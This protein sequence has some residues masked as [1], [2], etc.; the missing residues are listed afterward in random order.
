MSH[1][2][3]ASA[4]T[5]G[6]GYTTITAP[7]T[8]GAFAATIGAA[9]PVN[10]S[11][12]TVNNE[13]SIFSLGGWVRVVEF[14]SGTDSNVLF[15]ASGQFSLEVNAS[16]L[17]LARFSSNTASRSVQS[18]SGI[19]DNEWHY[20]VVAFQQAND[21]T[22][23]GQVK[24]VVDG[25]PV[26]D[27]GIVTSASSSSV[28]QCVI[29]SGQLEFVSWTIWSV[30]LSTKE[31]QV[32]DFGPPVTGS[33]MAHDM[34]AAFNFA[35]GVAKDESGNNVPIAA[36]AGHSYLPRL[37]LSNGSVLTPAPADGITLFGTSFSM[38]T[39]LQLPLINANNVILAQV[40]G[41]YIGVS[42]FNDVNPT[43]TEYQLFVNSSAL[44][45]QAPKAG[46]VHL[47]FFL[48]EADGTTLLF[49][50]LN[51][52]PISDGGGIGF[53]GII[54]KAPATLALVTG[55][56]I[57]MQGISLW[58]RQVT[59]TEIAA[60]MSGFDPTGTDGLIAYYALQHD[61]S[62]SVTNREATVTNGQL[63]DIVED[64][65]LSKQVLAA[66]DSAAPS[67]EDSSK[68]IKFLSQDDYLALAEKHNIDVETLVGY[69]DF[70]Q[71][72]RDIIDWFDEVAESQETLGG[73]TK[74]MLLRGLQVGEELRKAGVKTGQM[75]VVVEGEQTAVYYHDIDGPIELYRIDEILDPFTTWLLTIIVDVIAVLG[76]AFGLLTT[77]DRLARVVKVITVAL[78]TIKNALI[79]A[80]DQGHASAGEA[81]IAVIKEIYSAG[82]LLTVIKGLV[83]GSWWSLI[84]TALSLLGQILA[85]AFSGGALLAV[86][87]ALAAVAVSKLIYDL[88]TYPGTLVFDKVS[89]VAC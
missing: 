8:A 29:G 22:Q 37:S 27:T 83:T 53:P 77:A 61:L 25:V 41:A 31:M 63:V 23:K 34:V 1:A 74:E 52:V 10:F 62:N 87:L 4:V 32:P 36:Y 5:T 54:P 80:L 46:Y 85:A 56:T 55:D 81:V 65:G 30:F 9:L 82:L 75:E 3:L 42:A 13:Q 78:P 28:G 35:A 21:G 33:I 12:Q 71:G 79:D 11:G 16:G 19:A 43:T 47:T 69:A 88:T 76:A 7:S 26:L 15:Q 68:R 6:Q 44:R 73:D 2:E 72:H 86:K 59:S 57:S 49:A 18:D 64:E 24:I 39:W 20:V 38:M 60:D 84:F 14:P 89:G 58:N 51:G 17:L 48:K 45:F 50:W 40:Q 70:S 67:R 66:L